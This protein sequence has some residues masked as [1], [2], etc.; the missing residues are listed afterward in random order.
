MSDHEYAPETVIRTSFRTDAFIPLVLLAVSFILML[1]WQV[2]NNVGQRALLENALKRQEQAVTQ[3]QQVRANVAKLAT[4]LLEA[5]QTDD[6]ARAIAA[7]YIR[8]NHNAPGGAAAAA[9]PAK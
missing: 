6:T 8:D 4:D 1:V 9:S 5:A 2:R 3:A 7:K